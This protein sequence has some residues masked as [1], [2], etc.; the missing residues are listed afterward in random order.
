MR[1]VVRF[2]KKLTSLQKCKVRTDK[3]A[4]CSSSPLYLL[5]YY[6]FTIKLLYYNVFHRLVSVNE[7]VWLSCGDETHVCAVAALVLDTAR[8]ELLSLPPALRR[9]ALARCKDLHEAAL[10]SL[11]VC[12]H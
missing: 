5:D 9:R 1:N 2:L 11:Q 12:T 8:G 10:S 7:R 6:Y 3:V 4:S